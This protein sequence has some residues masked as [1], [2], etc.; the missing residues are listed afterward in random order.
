MHKNKLA[1]LILIISIIF[2]YS[3]LHSMTL[4]YW[5][6][7]IYFDSNSTLLTE[8]SKKDLER[9]TKDIINLEMTLTL[10]I[11]GH[12]DERGTRFYNY[13]LGLERARKVRDYLIKI[14]VQPNRLK[15]KSFG[16]DRPAALGYN[17]KSWSKNRRVYLI[18]HLTD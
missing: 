3:Q 5:V 14:G 10:T 17:E 8:K 11:E 13:S 1:H 7:V 16:E 6:P 12:C 4:K 2:G 18:I 15:I 9:Y